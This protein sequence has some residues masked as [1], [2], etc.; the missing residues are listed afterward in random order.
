QGID[1]DSVDLTGENNA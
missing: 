1:P